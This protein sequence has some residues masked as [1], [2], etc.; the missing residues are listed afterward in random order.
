MSDT[1]LV[2]A[3]GVEE[4]SAHTRWN[5]YTIIGECSS[6]QTGRAWADPTA[7]LPLFITTLT[8][9]T[10]LVGLLPAL[11]RLGY[12]LPQVPVAALLGHRPRRAPFLRWGVFFGRLPF[13]LFVAYLWTQGAANHAVTLAFLLFADFSV[14]LGNGFVAVPWQDII[15][16]SI[17]PRIRGR[18]WGTMQL[19]GALG[20][21]AAGTL[22][23][24]VLHHKGLAFPAN[25]AVLFTVAAV[26]HAGSTLGCF[27]VREPVRPVLEQREGLSHILKTAWSLLS[28]PSAFRS[29]VLIAI[30]G[31]G[32]AG[33]MPF[34]IVYATRH[35]GVPEY[36]AGVYIS[37][38][39]LG[40]AALSLVW[41]WLNDRRGTRAVLRGG[42][43]LLLV[44]PLVALII[45]T[46]ARAAHPTALPYLFALVFL[47]GP[48]SGSA[49]FMGTVNYMFDLC[50]HE[51][52]HRYISLLGTLSA[53][54]ILLPLAVGW[55]LK[56][57]PFPVMFVALAA[58][59][60]AAMSIGYRMPQA[61]RR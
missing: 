7:V 11:Q 2:G 45:P 19:V 48:S 53:P 39:T 46:L 5:F 1:T 8:P 58:V 61:R 38:A 40:T 23:G 13:V 36:M 55:L 49:F 52:R 9:S 12:V 29:L 21:F 25:F 3:A 60:G 14:Q 41:G 57:V 54:S 20:G 15:A 56:F 18:F 59:A 4:T 34:Y 17:P 37:V 35:L 31:F 47:T 44:T 30:L 32:L 22:V 51:E 26:F 16:K 33:T 27:L 28:R 43:V 10:A 50:S 6:F 24:V 42:C